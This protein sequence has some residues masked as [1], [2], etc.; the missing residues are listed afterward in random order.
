[1]GANLSRLIHALIIL[2]FFFSFEVYSQEVQCYRLLG[3]DNTIF[4]DFNLIM[5]DTKLGDTIFVMSAKA[6]KRMNKNFTGFDEVLVRG[7]CYELEFT[8]KDSL[9]NEKLGRKYS[10]IDHLEI[11]IGSKT[12]WDDQLVQV[13][14]NYTE[15][16]YDLCY[17]RKQ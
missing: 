6:S 13:P 2:F 8:R 10:R 16:I 15:Q 9:F 11:N 4:K 12:I 1:M 7:E 5:F 14:I 3:I 17:K